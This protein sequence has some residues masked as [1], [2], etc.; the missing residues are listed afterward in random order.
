MIQECDL[1]IYGTVLPVAGSSDFIEDGAVVIQGESIVAVGSRER[2][3]EEYSPHEYLGLSGGLVMPGLVNLHTHAAMSCMRG[4]ADDIPLMA[5]LQEHIFPAEQK[6]TREIVYYSSLLSGIEMIKSGTTTFCDMYLFAGD[7]AKAARDIGL[8]GAIGEVIFDF[9]SPNYGDKESGLAYV[10]EMFATYD[11]DSLIRVTVDPHSVYTCSPGLLLQLKEMADDFDAPYVIHL[12]ESKDEV[13]SVMRQYGRTPVHHLDHLGILDERVIADHCVILS[14]PEIELFAG[15]GASICHC[16]ESNMKLA[17]GVA[18]IPDLLAAGVNI[19]L[20][21]DGSASNNDVDL[22]SEMD[23]AA[24]L[25]KAYRRDPT[26]VSAREVLYMTTLG[27]ARALRSGAELG[28]LEP[29]KKADIIVLDL[30]QPHLVP[31]YDISSHLVYAA[32][33]GDVVHSVV[34]GRIIMRDSIITTVDEAEIFSKMR[35]VSS[36]LAG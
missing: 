11:D 33:G 1:L 8:R 13:D 10:K 21:T 6:M 14:D 4:M 16:P 25:H 30:D 27:G 23:T 5:W 17:S 26:V 9:F 12:S 2:L 7:V 3:E 18:P 35:E 22:F 28:S 20:G 24:K 31:M 19:G 34:N 29:G 32:R 36:I 15:R